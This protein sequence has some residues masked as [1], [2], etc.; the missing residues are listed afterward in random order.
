MSLGE[1]KDVYSTLQE[2]DSLLEVV[3]KK[4]DTLRMEAGHA[5]GNW[6][7]LEYILFRTTG[8]LGRLGLPP[9]IDAGIQKLQRMLATIRILHS[10]MIYLEMASMAHPLGWALGAISVGSAL[11]MMSD[12]G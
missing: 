6:R 7:E 10:A 5:T 9:D 11:V 12:M 1:I 8:L 2:I 3:Q 4:T